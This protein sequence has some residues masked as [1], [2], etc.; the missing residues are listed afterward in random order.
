M[1]F[2]AEQRWTYRHMHRFDQLKAALSDKI[3]A[4]ARDARRS[5]ADEVERARQRVDRR[6][7]RM[8]MEAALMAGVAEA[9]MCEN[10]DHVDWDIVYGHEKPKPPGQ[11]P[12]YWYRLRWK[13]RLRFALRK[14]L[15][16]VSC[17]LRS[18][19]TWIDDRTYNL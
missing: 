14:L 8:G 2:T 18:T 12:R 17:T 1:G 4:A 10:T 19:A 7:F 13:W 15:G 3:N 16:W 6:S 9:D 11:L 5:I